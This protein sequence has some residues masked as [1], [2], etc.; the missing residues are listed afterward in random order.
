MVFRFARFFILA[1]ISSYFLL[2]CSG[3]GLPIIGSSFTLS[4][5]QVGI[6]DYLI[7]KNSEIYRG[8]QPNL[9]GFEYLKKNNIRTIIKLNSEQLD[10]E[11]A[12]ANRFGIKFVPAIIESGHLYSA[13]D[14]LDYSQ[15][16]NAMKV[17]IDSKNW[18]IYVHCQNGWDRTGLVI[19][20]F[21]V[22][23]EH[24]S[25]EDAYNEMVMNGFSSFHRLLLGGIQDYWDD[26]DV[27]SCGK[28]QHE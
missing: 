11:K 20:L 9:N 28:W 24:F 14:N 2:G 1:I 7:V 19:A 22:C 25:K 5:S 4:E 26:F 17:L 12:I 27:S 10:S 15:I 8:G 6:P 21:R 3:I 13:M 23:Y 16:D 18:P